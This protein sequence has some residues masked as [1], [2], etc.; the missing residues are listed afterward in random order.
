MRIMLDNNLYLTDFIIYSSNIFFVPLLYYTHYKYIR[1]IK[2]FCFIF[3]QFIHK[4]KSLHVFN[5]TQSNLTEI[6]Y[7][8]ILEMRRRIFYDYPF[9]S[10]VWYPD[11][12]LHYKFM[13]NLCVFFFH[14]ILAYLIDFSMLIFRQ[15]RL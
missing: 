14:I 9:E 1:N 10:Q 5:I 6:T 8:E 7:G 4:S 3:L 12:N 2:S 13:H 15:K 11:G